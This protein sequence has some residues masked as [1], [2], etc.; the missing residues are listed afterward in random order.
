[1]VDSATAIQTSHAKLDVNID[2]EAKEKLRIFVRFNNQL[3]RRSGDYEAFV[4][5]HRHDKRNRLRP[6]VLN[7]LRKMSDR[8]WQRVAPYVQKLED[9]GKLSNLQRYWIVNGFACKATGRACRVLAALKDV[10]FVYLQRG[11][12]RQERIYTPDS[13]YGDRMQRLVQRIY[14]Q[15]IRNWAD[16]S[17]ERFSIEGLEIPWNIR[18]IRA[19]KVWR[20]ERVYGSGV[21]VAVNDNGIAVPPALVRALWR[22]TREELNG[23]D[24]D[25]NGYVDDL[26]GY[27][28]RLDSHFALKPDAHGTA[29]A[30]IIAG[31]PLNKIRLATGIAP[32][33]RLMSL[34]GMGYLRAY[35]YALANG[36]DIM[37]L[38]FMFIRHDLGHYRGVYRL[39]HEHLSAAGVLSVG[40]AG[41]FGPGG[42]LLMPAGK[43]IATPKD[44]PCVV[45]AAGITQNGIAPEMSSRGPC[46]WS[47]VKFYND[48]PLDR[49]LRKPDVTGCFGG[50]PI[51][52][53]L[54]SGNVPSRWKIV[55]KEAQLPIKN[56]KS[57]VP[58]A[59]AIV[60]GPGGNSFSGPHVAGVAALML[61]ANPELNPW[62]VK[63]LIEQ[64]CRDLGKPGWD[65]VYGAGLIDALEAV[66]AAKKILK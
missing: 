29:C 54:P 11:P 65:P 5:K 3:F 52:W 4:E 62:E 53:I 26:F 25:R 33:A 22:N 56:A 60:E 18:R 31:R 12:A 48:F 16:D 2:Q 63:T 30:G 45:A 64:T 38:S 50:Y 23:I 49:P 14:D 59:L 37:S 27:N 57:N 28:F 6:M 15:A 41:N 55:S 21:I 35:E 58:L 8:S 24:D 7:R 39:A 13:F 9:S 34:S 36:A 19:D 17:E 66:R 32:R 51:W 44:I 46:T 47:G 61:S 20:W 43:Q 42:R 10:E 1:M 40:G